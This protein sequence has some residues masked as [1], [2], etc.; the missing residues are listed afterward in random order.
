MGFEPIIYIEDTD[1]HTASKHSASFALE[2]IR[3]RAFINSL[4]CELMMKDL[5]QEGIDVS[6]VHN[7]HNFRVINENF[8]NADIMLP[9]IHIDV[10]VFYDE[11]LIFIPKE[12]F[13]Y[14]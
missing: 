5:A 3:K 9:N 6:N 2:D 13:T 8:D 12:H 1:K 14:V 10:R 7:I 11:N 4:G